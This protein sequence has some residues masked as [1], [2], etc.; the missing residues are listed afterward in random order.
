ML[1]HS[2]EQ[3]SPEWFEKRIL[4]MTGSHAQAIGNQGK[5]LISYI[6]D[7]M[8]IYETGESNNNFI[9]KDIDRGIETEAEARF[10]YEMESG[11]NTQDVGFIEHNKYSGCSPDFLIE[12]NGKKS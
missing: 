4:K 3:L 10:V 7:L 6:Q 8:V 1:I 11:N 12:K 2:I 5:G 9:N